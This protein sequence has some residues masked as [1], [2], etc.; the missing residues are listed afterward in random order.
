MKQFILLMVIVGNAAAAIPKDCLA[1]K[2]K[3]SR[4]KLAAI[5]EHMNKDPNMKR[6]GTNRIDRLV[7]PKEVIL[8]LKSQP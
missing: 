5:F 2:S 6:N 3:T 7:V 1:L 4:Q 8:K